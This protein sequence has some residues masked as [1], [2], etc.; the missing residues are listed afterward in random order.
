MSA[1]SDKSTRPPEQEFTRGM[2]QGR[3]MR[4]CIALDAEA[5]SHPKQIQ[6]RGSRARSCFRGT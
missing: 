6:D 5:G 1:L 2:A 3:S 4:P